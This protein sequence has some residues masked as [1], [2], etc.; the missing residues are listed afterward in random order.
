MT[1]DLRSRAE[2]ADALKL[3]ATLLLPCEGTDDHSWRT[4]ERC[5]AMYGL[6][7]RFPVTMRLLA[8][9]QTMVT[10]DPR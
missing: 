3:L 1:A 8:H 6:E 4:C 5:T 9:V 2:R 7:M 10:H